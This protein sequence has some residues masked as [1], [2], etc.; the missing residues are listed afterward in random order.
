MRAVIFVRQKLSDKTWKGT[1]V[2]ERAAINCLCK[3]KALFRR[4]S[5]AKHYTDSL[6]LKT[7]KNIHF[8]LC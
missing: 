2:V 1:R 6:K 4:A 5:A 3:A 7:Y 8:W